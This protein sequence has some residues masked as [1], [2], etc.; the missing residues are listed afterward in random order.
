MPPSTPASS[1]ASLAA[2]SCPFRFFSAHLFGKTQRPVNSK[3]SQ[4]PCRAATS[5]IV[6]PGSLVSATRPSL[7]RGLQRRR[8]SRPVI[9]STTPSVE[10]PHRRLK[11][12]L[13]SAIDSCPGS[14]R[15]RDA[16]NLRP[17]RFYLGLG[18]EVFGE[19]ANKSPGQSRGF[20]ASGRSRNRLFDRNAAEVSYDVLGNI[21][22][23]AKDVL[24]HQPVI[25][26]TQR[27]QLRLLDRG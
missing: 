8:L 5:R 4:T 14:P 16:D 18:N 2:I 10:S 6:A 9:I 19:L 11:E 25:L 1:K 15:R 17:K 21:G 27:H 22:G 12:L 26:V 7:P 24:F 13:K 23:L 20:F 3:L